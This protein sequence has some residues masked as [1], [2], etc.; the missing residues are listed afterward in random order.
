MIGKRLHAIAGILLG[1]LVLLGCGQSPEPGQDHFY[2]LGTRITVSSHHDIQIVSRAIEQQARAWEQRWDPWDAGELAEI[3][4]L[5]R[6]QGSAPLP[7]TLRAG[8]QTALDH[9]AAS[10]GLFHP[11]LGE[12]IQAW[13]FHRQPMASDWQP[14][15]ESHLATLLAGLPP[16]DLLTIDEND[17]LSAEGQPF[18]LDLGGIAK[19]MLLDQIKQQHAQDWPDGTLINLGGDVLALG[20]RDAD[21]EQA[22]RVGILDPRG[23]GVLAGLSMAD[24]ECAMT[25]GDYERG[26]TLNGRHYHHLLDPRT[27]RPARGSA[28]VTVIDRDCARADAAATAL[29]VAGP[30]QWMEIASQMDVDSVMLVTDQGQIEVSRQLAKRLDFPNRQALMIERELP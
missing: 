1:L 15:E 5:L 10:K 2:A 14:P 27:A 6:E 20:Q 22:W 29:F 11:G 26:Q 16:A 3:N 8:I 18:Q 28:S 24:G 12:I 13:G 4:R 25:S 7:D 19:G 21:R 30:E 17:K 9:A 23:E